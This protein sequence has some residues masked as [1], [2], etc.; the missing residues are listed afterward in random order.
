MYL[1][2]TITKLK[3]SLGR[4]QQQVRSSRR[5]DQQPQKHVI[6]NCPVSGTKRKKRKE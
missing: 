4:V 5:Q 6:G 3:N 2:S 1:K